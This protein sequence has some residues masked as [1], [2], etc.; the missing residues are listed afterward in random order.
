METF[1]MINP[2]LGNRQ[3]LKGM[4][5]SVA[6]VCGRTNTDCQGMHISKPTAGIPDRRGYQYR[7]AWDRA[8]AQA[9]VEQVSCCFARQEAL[10]I[11]THRGW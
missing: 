9:A 1:C 7:C 4:T 5:S 2:F 3:R 6:V 10:C 11:G 8:H